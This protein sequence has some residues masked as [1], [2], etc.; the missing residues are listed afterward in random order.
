[1]VGNAHGLEEQGLPYLNTI[2]QPLM[3]SLRKKSKQES[4]HLLKSN[5]YKRY[6]CPSFNGNKRRLARAFYDADKI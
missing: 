2:K 5:G 1:M 4:P 6:T 3:P